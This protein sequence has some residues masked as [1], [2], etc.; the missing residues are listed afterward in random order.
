MNEEKIPELKRENWHQIL[1]KLKLSAPTKVL[2]SVCFI[3]SIND[4]DV[5]LKIS[6]KYKPILTSTHIKLLSKA[7]TELY[8]KPLNVFISLT[9][10][11]FEVIKEEI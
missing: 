4:N 10:T 11:P 9:D 8:N 5:S 1:Q 6:N 3:A 2:G 7:F